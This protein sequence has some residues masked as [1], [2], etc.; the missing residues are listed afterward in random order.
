MGSVDPDHDREL[1]SAYLDILRRS[2]ERSQASIERAVGLLPPA[3][4]AQ[5]LHVVGIGLTI[6]AVWPATRDLLLVLVPGMERDGL[7]EE[8][9]A[10]LDAALSRCQTLGDR[11]TEAELRWNLGVLHQF[12]ARYQ[13]AQQELEASAALFEALGAT[14]D[15]ARALRS[16]AWVAQRQRRLAEA[17]RLVAEIDRLLVSRDPERAYRLNVKGDIA[18]ARRQWQLARVCY[19][20]ELCLLH[21]TQDQR[22]IAWACVNLGLAHAQLQQYREAQV[23]YTRAIDL[24]GLI[25]DPVH[26]AVARMN[27]GIVFA[28]SQQPEAALQQYAL[29]EPAFRAAADV[30]RRAMVYNNVGY[31]YGLLLRWPEAE[32]AYRLAVQLH[33]EAGNS[34]G[35]V[36]SM[37]NLAESLEELGRISEA[38]ALLKDALRELEGVE[39]G[40]EKQSL[41]DTIT[42][43]LESLARRT[44]IPVAHSPGGSAASR[45]ARSGR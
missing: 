38:R 12:Q 2:L 7:R 21:A 3:D 37:D 14:H 4:V 8:L 44:G 39:P 9:H 15:Q 20:Q 36:S 31:V 19:A 45:S 32:P 34:A 25:G 1:E 41:R 18:M 42:T 23:W 5:A 40:A 24:F 30:R 11:A 10:V 35:M 22:T 29:A 28:M 13:Q 16:L 17:D 27:L 6:D 33:R 26:C 43:H